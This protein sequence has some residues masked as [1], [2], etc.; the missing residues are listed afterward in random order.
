MIIYDGQV[1]DLEYLEYIAGERIYREHTQ[2]DYPSYREL[3]EKRQKHNA[4]SDKDSQQNNGRTGSDKTDTGTVKNQTRD[5]DYLSAV[6]RG[7]METANTVLD[8]LNKV[9]NKLA[10]LLGYAK[11]ESKL[12][13]IGAEMAKKHSEVLDLFIEGVR[14]ASENLAYTENTTGEGGVRMQSRNNTKKD[15]QQSATSPLSWRSPYMAR[16]LDHNRVVTAATDVGI[17][18]TIPQLSE[19][20]KRAIIVLSDIRAAID[21]NSEVYGSRKTVSANNLIGILVSNG[22][23]SRANNNESVYMHD[24]DRSVRISNHSA[25]ASNFKK[26]ENLSI[27]LRSRG[28]NTTFK[29]DS[30]K[31]AVE[32]VFRKQYLNE[33]PESLKALLSDIGR[34]IATGIYE[35]HA[36]AQKINVSGNVS[37]F[38]KPNTNNSDT[39]YQ[40]RE[41]WLDE[42]DFF[43]ADDEI[44]DVFA[45]QF[46]TLSEA[47]GEVLRNTADIEIAPNT[48]KN[49]LS[50]IIREYT[51][52]VLSAQ[53][54]KGLA[55]R[56]T[57]DKRFLM[58]SSIIS[59]QPKFSLPSCFV[60]F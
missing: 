23:F 54:R 12:G 53:T 43:S 33:H 38:Y 42:D 20:V 5:A 19:N 7:D 31:N 47:I 11:P 32:A 37:K 18:N 13:R 60:L 34:F 52:A 26:Q 40:S 57:R 1:G 59:C 9:K 46:V 58:F 6:K 2:G 4:A 28:A 56:Q 17:A 50:R 14:T 10:S 30:S 48:V 24:G 3:K 51:P 8:L 29:P 16:S 44:Q 25:V 15:T 49:I 27:V 41:G 55:S 45:R 36:G 21:N 39:R 35:D 22:V